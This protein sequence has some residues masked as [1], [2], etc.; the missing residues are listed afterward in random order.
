MLGPPAQEKG[1]APCLR[2]G[3]ERRAGSP[4]RKRHGCR[5]ESR[6]S[7]RKRGAASRAPAVSGSSAEPAGREGPADAGDER[8]GRI[9]GGGN[10]RGLGTQ[11]EY[12]EGAAVSS[13]RAIGGI[14]PAAGS[15]PVGHGIAI[16]LRSASELGP[17]GGFWK[18]GG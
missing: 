15:Q 4:G 8:S 11:R 9:F 10:R 6:P 17:R 18:W 1:A 2:V 12:G 16:A 7:A 5:W 3:S 14:A 13:T